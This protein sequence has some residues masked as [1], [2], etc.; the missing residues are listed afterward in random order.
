LPD[1]PTIVEAGFPNLVAEN[2]FGISGPPGMPKDVTEKIYKALVEV[3]QQPA[4][5]KKL[6]DT[7]LDI[8]SMSQGEYVKYVEKQASD[9]TP[10][11]KASGAKL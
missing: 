7:G 2:Y 6:E 5:R 1:V 9:W 3:M 11:V 4:T 8:K 10:A